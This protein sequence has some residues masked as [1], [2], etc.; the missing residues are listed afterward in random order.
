[1]SNRLADFFGI[2]LIIFACC[3][4]AFD[5]LIRYPLISS[6]V[7]A[8]SIVF[9]EHL[10][11]TVIFCIVFFKQIPNFSNLKF[12]HIF[13][14]VVVGGFGSALAT[15][16][17]TRAF[18]FLNPSLVILLQKFQPVIAILLARIFLQESINKM[19]ILWAIVC[20]I[21]GLLV[22][23]QDILNVISKY[24]SL[25]ELW[26]KDNAT[27]GYLL[28]II[29]IVGWGA[30][31][32]FGKK[33]E[34]EGFGNEQIMGGRF[35]TGFIFLIPFAYGNVDTF[36]HNIEV[37]SKVSL[38]V[39]ISGLLAMYLYYQG[40]RR[41]SAKACSLAEMFFPFMAVI[42]NWLFLGATL[43]ILQ[44]VGGILLL[45]GSIVIQIKHY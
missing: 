21:G 13:Y 35:I 26:A 14:F 39:L 12:K 41:T 42:V 20:V 25:S 45:V 27:L 36:T 28:V 10:I 38:M 33:L 7:S 40:L 5:S 15:L 6:G 37:Y 19:F 22:S 23:Y 29:S 43:S 1:M 11:L 9:Y 32:V 4:W 2:V 16:A 18:F 17:F 31:T 3:F 34:N 30:S 8:I 44:I 24:N